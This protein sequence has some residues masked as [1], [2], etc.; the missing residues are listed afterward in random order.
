MSDQAKQWLDEWVR[1][2]VV[3]APYLQQKRQVKDVYAP[4]CSLDAAKV[5]ITRRELEKAADGCRRQNGHRSAKKS[6]GERDLRSDFVDLHRCR[7]P[8]RELAAERRAAYLVAT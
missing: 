5:G 3:A 8:T 7:L 1:I 6:T 2:R 4:A